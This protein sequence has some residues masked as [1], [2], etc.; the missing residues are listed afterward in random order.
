[1][2]KLRPGAITRS[3]GGAGVLSGGDESE[4]SVIGGGGMQ[5][6][7]DMLSGEKWTAGLVAEF[8]D[9]EC[10]KIPSVLSCDGLLISGF[11]F[12]ELCRT[13]HV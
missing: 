9:H 10:V 2:W 1:M 12:Y 4:E 8:D 7:S 11:W 13:G 5:P 6:V 3:N